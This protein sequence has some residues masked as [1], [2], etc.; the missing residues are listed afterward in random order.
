MQSI[1]LL[2]SLLECYMYFE[3]GDKKPDTECVNFSFQIFG[4][5]FLISSL[6]P[7]LLLPLISIIFRLSLS[8]LML[9]V[10]A[11]VD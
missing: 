2:H 3:H 8:L 9:Y 4:Q 7:S 10:R 5:G 11:Y 1:E 6:P